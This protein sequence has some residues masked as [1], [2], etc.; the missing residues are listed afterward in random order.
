MIP[1]RVNL[2]K[3]TLRGWEEPLTIF[4]TEWHIGCNSPWTHRRV[5]GGSGNTKDPEFLLCD[6][7]K[8]TIVYSM[9]PNTVKAIKNLMNELN[10]NRKSKHN[11][12]ASNRG[13][14]GVHNPGNNEQ[15]VNSGKFTVLNNNNRVIMKFVPNEPL[16]RTNLQFRRNGNGIQHRHKWPDWVN[17]SPWNTLQAH[18]SSMYPNI[19]PVRPSTPRR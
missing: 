8:K 13:Y 9:A 4:S 12:T 19:T 10:R 3:T 1:L 6:R 5:Y 16:N 17:W 2:V 15:H 14:I 18:N 7:V 11:N